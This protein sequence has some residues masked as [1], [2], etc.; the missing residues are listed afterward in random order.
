[1]TTAITPKSIGLILMTVALTGCGTVSSV[2]QD[3]S[4]AGND[5]KKRQT[6][7]DSISRIYSGV[8]YD[9]CIMHAPELPQKSWKGTPTASL[10]VLDI[11]LSGLTDTLVLPY[12]AYK[13]LKHGNIEI[14]QSQTSAR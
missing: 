5:L 3:D 12:T 6:Y 9:F 14:Y 4:V 10:V 11:M 8:G 1:M 7:C 2:L 13:Q